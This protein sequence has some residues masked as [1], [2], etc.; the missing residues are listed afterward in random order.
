V[1][2]APVTAVEYLQ[3]TRALAGNHD[4]GMAIEET[5]S[6][7]PAGQRR[8]AAMTSTFKM[9][10]FAPPLHWKGSGHFWELKSSTT[11]FFQKLRQVRTG[12]RFTV[13]A[14]GWQVGD[15]GWNLCK[16]LSVQPAPRNSASDC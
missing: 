1:W 14:S 13:D 10:E 8:Q 12:V 16:H 5:L 4:L 3:A 6:S 9:T 2:S 11:T 15:L 7:A